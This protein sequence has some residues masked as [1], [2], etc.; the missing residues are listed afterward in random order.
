MNYVVPYKIGSQSAK[1]LAQKLGIKRSKGLKRFRRSTTVLN[2]GSSTF[3]P[4]GVNVRVINRP[5]AVAKAS[6]KVTA[7]QTMRAAGVSTVDFTFS[8]TEAA[9]W[10]NDGYL[11]YGR[12]LTQAHSGRGIHILTEDS[13]VPTLPLYTKGIAKAHEYRVHVAFGSIIDFSKKRRRDGVESNPLIKNLDNGWVF[14]REGIV[15][16][17]V[18]RDQAVRAVVALGLDFAAVD[19]L[20]R[21]R[22]NKAWILEAN[23]APG[24]QGTTLERYAQ[25][26]RS[27]L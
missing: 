3:V 9:G 25:V 22:E 18:V 7:F 26:M 23:S 11:V 12:A 27:R 15:L 19:V 24:L 17:D 4:R 16:P 10:V 14:C 2:W 6:N 21:E 1:A 20:Y 5:E 13:V 8:R